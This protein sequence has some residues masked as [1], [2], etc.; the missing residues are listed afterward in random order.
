MSS[1]GSDEGKPAWSWKEA[2][3]RRGWSYSSLFI[4]LLLLATLLSGFARHNW[5]CDI[6]ANLRVQQVLASL[7][8]LGMCLIYRRWIWLVVPTACL[9]VHL[10]WLISCSPSPEQGLSPDQAIGVM[11]C[12]VNSANQSFEKVFAEI[13][14]V[15]PDVFVLLE[16]TSRWAKQVESRFAEVYPHSIVRPSDQG[17]FGIGLYSR[18]PIQES[19][20]FPLNESIRSIEARIE[21]N[22]RSYRVIGT[23]PLPPISSDNFDSRN[24]HLRLLAERIRHPQP[25]FEGDSTIVMGD[26]NLTPW[27]PWF[28]DFELASGLRRTERNLDIRPTWHVLPLLPFGLSLDHIFVSDDLTWQKRNVGGPIGSDHR[29]VN[30]SLP[31]ASSAESR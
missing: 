20:I 15:Q 28:H 4:V 13:D 11:L 16:I 27:S 1:A 9:L 30:M 29:G 6:L 21:F 31:L 22:Q 7:F 23:H 3:I 8:L 25:G 18:H 17:N 24:E 2:I 26:F 10:P 14:E 19:E 5:I 12:N